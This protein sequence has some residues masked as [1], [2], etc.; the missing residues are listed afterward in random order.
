MAAAK[1]FYFYVHADANDA[2]FIF[3][4]GMRLF[5]LDGGSQ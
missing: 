1:A 5:H 3:A 2:P 4:A